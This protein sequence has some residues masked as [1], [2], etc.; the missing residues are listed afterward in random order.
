LCKA[1]ELGLLEFFE[2]TSS[3]DEALTLL[4]ELNTDQGF[5]YLR[6]GEKT[7]P[8]W[9]IV[10]RLTSAKHGRHWQNYTI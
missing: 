10:E 4:V 6:T 7:V 2:I 9:A 8:S 3:D 5:R 1:K